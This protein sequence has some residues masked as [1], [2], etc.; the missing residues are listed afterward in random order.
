MK[1]EI[2][3]TNRKS[4]FVE[5][6]DYCVGSMGKDKE[7]EGHFLEVTEWSNCEGYDIHIHDSEGERQ[8]HLSYGQFD[9]IKKCVKVIDKTH[10]KK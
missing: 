4:T 3:V 1:K 7:K 2:E 9:A 8:I 5:L 6:K 10:H